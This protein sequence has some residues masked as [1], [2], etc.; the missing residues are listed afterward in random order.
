LIK[1]HLD[2]GVANLAWCDLF[3]EAQVWVDF[4]WNSDHALL[5]LNF[6]R[7]KY[8]QRNSQ[9]FRYEASWA[10]DN[11]Y[12]T[13]I[14]KAWK[15]PTT[16]ARNWSKP[17]GEPRV[18]WM[19]WRNMGT[20]KKEGGMGFRDFRSFNK[21][22]L[23][24]QCWRLWQNPDSFL[25]KIMKGKYFASNT[26]LEASLGARPSYAWRSIHGSCSLLKAGLI[27]RVGNGARIRIWKDKWLPRPTTYMIHSSPIGL[28]P[29]ATVSALINEDTRWWDL[30]ALNYMFSKEEVSII[31][32]IPVSMSNKEDRCIWRG[33]KNGQFTVRSAYHLQQELTFNMR[34]RVL[35][36]GGVV[37]FGARF[38]GYN[39]LGWKKNFYGRPAKK[40]YLHR[41]TYSRGRLW[42]TRYAQ[43]AAVNQNQYFISF[44]HVIRQGMLGV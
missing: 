2:R 8:G 3:P 23:A 44:G 31:Q 11:E 41:P 37:R 33:T 1:E 13:L 12:K 6:N 24:K 20:R 16:L 32:S 21:A 26:F 29:E 38:G 15:Q 39:S 27:W 25:A 42:I 4:S 28:H 9:R 5:I 43:Y 35:V 18:H 22:L 7:H 36:R 30:T 17:N 14:E 40:F 10:L 34:P 19:N